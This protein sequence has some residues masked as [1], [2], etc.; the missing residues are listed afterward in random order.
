[1]CLA[2]AS[3]SK[4]DE[5]EREGDYKLPGHDFPPETLDKIF[6]VFKE[7]KREEWPKFMSF[8]TE[9]PQLSKMVFKRTEERAAAIEDPDLAMDMLTML[10]ALKK[11]DEEIEAQ[12]ALLKVF[13]KAAEEDIDPLVTTRRAEIG[14]AFFTYVAMRA[15]ALHDDEK[16]RE[17]LVTLAARIASTCDALDKAAEN[18]EAVEQAGQTLQKL[19]EVES[20]QEA[21]KMIDEL[22]ASGG[23]NPA[24]MLTAAK[25]YNSVKESPYVEEEVKDVMAHLYFKMKETSGR[26]QPPEVRILKYILS[27]ED[28]L[29]R[30]EALD[31]AFTPGPPVETPQEDYLCTTPER[32]LVTVQT[33]L[34]TYD[35]QKTTRMG[36]TGE[37]AELMSP[38]VIER[39]REIETEIE[40]EFM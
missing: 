14:P 8:S 26:Q 33:V 18:Q 29:Q 24:L 17:E 20:L 13:Q 38:Q 1:V 19:L 16:Q 3:E 7:K 5:F 15:D 25:A 37:A 35:S 39:M 27:M 23:L 10:K 12:R 4:A 34:Q 11:V 2:Q 28:P 9:W 22:A 21:D 6:D 36:L 40:K 32:L 31:A 30:K